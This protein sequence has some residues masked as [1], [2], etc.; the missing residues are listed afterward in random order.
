MMTT[1]PTRETTHRQ[2]YL[3][4]SQDLYLHIIMYLHSTL[5]DF[6]RDYFLG[7][8]APGRPTVSALD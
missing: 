2:E 5:C 8:V 4:Y 1:I 6:N 3:Q 7:A